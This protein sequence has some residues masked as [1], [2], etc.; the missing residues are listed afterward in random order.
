MTGDKIFINSVECAVSSLARLPQSDASKYI[1]PGLVV[2]K[3]IL[4]KVKPT[5]DA[6]RAVEQTKASFIEI[7]PAPLTTEQQA[8]RLF[9]II[10]NLECALN[11]TDQYYNFASDIDLSTKHLQQAQEILEF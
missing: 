8:N 7:E 11:V 5:S 6:L 3:S 2:L 1:N 4:W 10:A 9:E